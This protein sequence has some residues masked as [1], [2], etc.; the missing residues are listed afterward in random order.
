MNALDTYC[1]A[2]KI[3]AVSAIFMNQSECSHFEMSSEEAHGV[4]IF[5]NEIADELEP[6]EDVKEGGD[7][8]N[9]NSISVK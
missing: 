3:R 8:D 4:S 5:L 6:K 7:H 2:S 1:L 9:S